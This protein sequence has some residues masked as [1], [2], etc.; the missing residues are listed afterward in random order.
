MPPL[1]RV[2]SVLQ[3][4]AP[5]IPLFV[6]GCA[7]GRTTLLQHLA[8]RLGDDTTSVYLDLERLATT[9]E[10]CYRAML[11]YARPDVEAASLPAPANL[12]S[13]REALV[14][15]LRILSEAVSMSQ[16]PYTFLLDEVLELRTFESFPG[17]KHVMNEVGQ[18]IARSRNRF[19]LA[20]R[21]PLRASRVLTWPGVIVMP[22]E[23]MGQ[24]G[25]SWSPGVLDGLDAVERGQ[26]LALTDGRLGYAVLVA[27][28]LRAARRTGI[29][30]AVGALSEQMMPGASLEQRL[31]L[32]YEVRLQRARGYGALRAILDALAELQPM[33]LTQVAQRM[34]RTPGSTKDY[35]SWLLDVDL[36]QVERKRYTMTDPL[37]RLWIRLNNGAAPPTDEVV[38]REV[39]RYATERFA[40][41]PQEGPA[42]ELATADAPAAA[43][44]AA[45][46]RP[47]SGDIIEID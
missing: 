9:P 35:L 47:S 43:S 8:G 3:A 21:F 42:P 38:A 45:P 28:A 20:S 24:D 22:V 23:R 5:G 44:H 29:A 1:D 37:L 16:R 14:A 6:G 15:M 34:R 12:Q 33:N 31:R 27:D 30:D 19:V 36:L 7:S 11:R 13:P 32:S 25:F 26:V 39:Q 10:Q 40:T 17:L 4:P 46:A 2:L 41:L 18:G